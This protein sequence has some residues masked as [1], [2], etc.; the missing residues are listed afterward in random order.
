MIFGGHRFLHPFQTEGPQTGALSLAQVILLKQ[1]DS[2]GWL[3]GGQKSNFT[4]HSAFKDPTSP[5]EGE[6]RV[7]C[8]VRCVCVWE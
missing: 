8:E 7:S 4:L 2:E 5:E 3:H 6:D 1:W